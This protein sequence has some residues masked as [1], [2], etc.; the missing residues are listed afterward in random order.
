MEYKKINQE[1]F[2]D[3]KQFPV[4]DS[5]VGI[6]NTRIESNKYNKNEFKYC[7]NLIREYNMSLSNLNVID[8]EWRKYYMRLVKNDFL[9]R[10]SKSKLTKIIYT[11]MCNLIVGIHR[12][13]I[14]VF[15]NR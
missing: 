14:E 15:I 4:I 9:D 13:K 6:F 1:S 7:A 8:K 10:L 2:G 12:Q 5:I 11:H 3:P